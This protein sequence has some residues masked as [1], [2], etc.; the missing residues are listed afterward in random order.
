M[1]IAR[2]MATPA[3]RIGRIVLGIIIIY[4][5]VIADKPLGY[6]LEVIGL[7]PIIAGALN[8]CLIG[9]L[10]G[11]PLKGQRYRR[12]MNLQGTRPLGWNDD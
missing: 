6:V 3:G 2:F 12:G 1:E 9:P 4:I 10:L 8:L 7:V 5:G 11:A